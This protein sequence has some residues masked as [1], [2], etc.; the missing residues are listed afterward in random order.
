MTTSLSI[1]TISFNNLA[2]LTE[3]CKS[4]D[5]QSV[6]PDEHW[7]IDG[8]SNNEI[9][10]WLTNN[11][12]PPYRKWIHERDKGISDAMNKG[13][14]LS[15]TTVI[16]LL[17]AGDKYYDANAIEQVIKHFDTDN[18]LIWTHGLYFQ[19]RGNI[20][21]VSGAPFEKDKLWKGMRT[22]SHPTMFIKKEVYERCGMFKP[23]YKIAMDYDLLIRIRNEKFKFIPE[24]LIYFS[25][26]GVSTT[27]F[28]KGLTE[29]KEIYTSYFGRSY[30][31]EFWQLRQKALS[32]FMSTK[33]GKVW[34]A[35]KNTKNRQ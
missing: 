5:M 17:H 24:P 23:D 15:K 2:E 12:Q 14:N 11:L 35:L 6:L 25:P 20:D 3:T 7:I 29:V 30:K 19:H 21:V 4:V 33:I 22:V 9:L 8:S 32:Y 1:V 27:Q 28:N 16:H 10:Y 34:F 13:I 18:T 26:G 31:L